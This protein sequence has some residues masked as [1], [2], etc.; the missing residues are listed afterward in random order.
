MCNSITLTAC[1]LASMKEVIEESM[2]TPCTIM[3]KGAA[4]KDEQGR[5]AY[6]SAASTETACR[7]MP[8]TSPREAISGGKMVSS[9]AHKIIL[10]LDTSISERDVIAIGAARY[11]VTATDSGRTN[12]TYLTCYCIK[13]N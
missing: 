3:V 13:S 12:A 7:L 6:A 2:T 8:P 11:E 9:S 1:E 4:S 10:P 5:N